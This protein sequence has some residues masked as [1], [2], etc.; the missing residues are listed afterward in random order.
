MEV[1]EHKHVSTSTSP[2]PARR[3]SFGAGKRAGANDEYSVLT[4]GDLEADQDDLVSQ[5]AELASLSKDRASILLLKFNWNKEKLLEQYFQNPDKT[6]ADAG[7]VQGTVDKLAPPSSQDANSSAEPMFMCN[8][9]F[10]QVPMS[11]TFSMGCTTEDHPEDHRFSVEAWQDYLSCKTDDGPECVFARCPMDGCQ[12]GVSPKVWEAILS[13]PTPGGDVEGG[14]SKTADRYTHA[15]QLYRRF[16]SESYVNINRNIKWCPSAGCS[17]ALKASGAVTHVTCAQCELQFCFKCGL[18]P[19][20]PMRCALLSVWMDKCNNESETANW[21]LANTKKCPKCTTRIEKNSGCNHMTCGMC[22]HEFC[23][24]CEGLWKDHGTTT[25][26]FYS[27]NKY[28]EA[29]A[30]QSDAHTTEDSKT[31]AKRELD[32]YLFYYQRY[33]THEQAGEYFNSFLSVIA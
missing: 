20:G 24:V 10:E 32:R 31:K 29:D 5:V 15:L 21:I 19:H 9:I 8:I 33:A 1:D 7:A 4:L 14:E 17:A 30:G 22:K 25:G 16:M 12:C 11:Q 6:C 26:G 23:W 13:Y 2:T 3:S 28:T 27:C 18:E